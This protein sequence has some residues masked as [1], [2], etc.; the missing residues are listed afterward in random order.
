MSKNEMLKAR[1]EKREEK[2]RDR[3]KIKWNRKTR[4]GEIRRKMK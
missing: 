3:N 4:K 1:K 2:K